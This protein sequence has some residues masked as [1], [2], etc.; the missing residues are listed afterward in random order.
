MGRLDDWLASAP[1]R[2]SEFA[3]PLVTLS[4]AQS[5]DGSI[6]LRRGQPLALSGAESLMLTH[7][8]RAVHDAVLVGIGTILADD[9]QLNAR[10]ATG[11]DPQVII[12]DSRLRIPPKA[13][14]IASRPRVFSTALAD[15]KVQKALEAAGVQIERQDSNSTERVDLKLALARLHEL[16][17]NTLMVEGGGEIISSFLASGFVDKAVITVTPKYIGGYKA[18]DLPAGFQGKLP[19]FQQVQ[20]ERYGQ[21]LVVWGDLVRV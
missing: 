12:L 2:P 10:L 3:R 15:A 18:A 11:K 20:F 6:A 9:P 4:Y 5:I 14:V 21:D 1:K 7:Q 13:K 8:L 16:G 17:L 19:R